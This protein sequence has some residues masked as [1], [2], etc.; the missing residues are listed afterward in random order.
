MTRAEKD[1]GEMSTHIAH[2]ALFH[3]SVSRKSWHIASESLWGEPEEFQ[4]FTSPAGRHTIA[5][6]M[7]DGRGTE[8]QSYL[9][10]ADTQPEKAPGLRMTSA[11]PSAA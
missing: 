3:P 1:L 4:E 5:V 6:K 9:S 8:G 10:R 11:A 7:T 2:T